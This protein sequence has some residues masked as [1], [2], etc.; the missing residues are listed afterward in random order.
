MTVPIRIGVLADDLIW[1]TRLVAI[2]RAAGAVPVPARRLVDLLDE[3]DL[4]GA[5]VDL[6]AR[7]Y[8]GIEAVRALVGGGVSVVCLAQHD[9]ESTRR[10]AIGAGARSVFPYRT[11]H[12][13]GADALS[14]WLSALGDVAA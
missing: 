2:L 9:D 8:D 4:A 5:V 14:R 11:L 1:S 12:E 3:R 6:T 7:A 10:A 13:K